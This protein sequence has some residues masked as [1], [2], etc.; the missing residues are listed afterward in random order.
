MV[1]EELVVHLPEPPLLARALRHQRSVPRVLMA[2]QREVTEAPPHAACGD[3]LLADDGHLDR[4]EL[5][6]ERALEVR[7]LRHL[8]PRRVAAQR[9]AAK[10]V[11]R[12]RGRGRSGRPPRRGASRGAPPQGATQPP[13]PLGALRPVPLI[14]VV[15]HAPAF[16]CALA[17]GDPP[18]A[19]GSY[20]PEARRGPPAP[21]GQLR[22]PAFASRRVRGYIAA[23]F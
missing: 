12:G 11:G 4:G 18:P 13:R 15:P 22:P 8:H 23:P 3:Q 5:G 17:V 9:E 1:E 7:V 16:R 14:L 19:P 10:S 20:S 21:R 6:A 2:R